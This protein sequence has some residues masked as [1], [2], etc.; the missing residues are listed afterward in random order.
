MGHTGHSHSMQMKKLPLII[1][2]IIGANWICL[3]AKANTVYL[4]E[5]EFNEKIDRAHAQCASIDLNF[6]SNFR[7]CLNMS[8]ETT[9][10]DSSTVE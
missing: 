4:P 6:T 9:F 2:V 3:P 7:D 10:I 1:V 8:L 5:T